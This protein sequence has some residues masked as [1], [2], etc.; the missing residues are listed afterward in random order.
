MNIGI[1]GCGMI[2]FAHATILKKLIKDAQL[3]L[4]YLN[5]E[6]AEKVASKFEA[7]GIYTRVEELLLK[8]NLDAVHILNPVSAHVEI[9]EKLFEVGVIYILRNLLLKQQLNLRGSAIWQRAREKLCVWDTVLL[10]CLL[11]S[12]QGKK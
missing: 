12:K 10:G 1:I 6:N 3:F 2:A 7:Q 11:F 4:C 8:E 5:V 9:A